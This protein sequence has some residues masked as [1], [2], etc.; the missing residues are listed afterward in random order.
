MR[1]SACLAARP[2]ALA[3]VGLFCVACARTAEERQMADLE[4]ELLQVRTDHDKF[5][6]RL[7]SLEAKDE[8]PPPKKTASSTGPSTP[9]LRVLHLNPDGSEVTTSSSEAAGSST[10]DDDAPR[11]VI[12]VQ[13][14]GGT[15]RKGGTGDVIEQTLPDETIGP[16]ITSGGAKPPSALDPEAKRTYDAALALVNAKEYDKGLEALAAFLVRY[17]DHPYA[18]NATY[19][20]GE[21]FFAQGQ[22]VRAVEQFDGIL[23]RFPLGNKTPDALLKLGLSYQKLGNPAKA[24]SYFDK[25]QSEYPRSDAA[26][27]IP[28]STS[29]APPPRAAGA[30]VQEPK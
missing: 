2:L 6:Q 25:L 3:L 30:G 28:S 24:K 15:K 4:K 1:F 19:W 5:D 13:G 16:P 11:P 12:R 8:D 9:A 14:A 17:P 23:A 18:A 7:S 22:Y 29:S 27:L 20:R 26:K 10:V 21:C